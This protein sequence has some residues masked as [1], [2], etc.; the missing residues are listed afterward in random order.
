MI[1]LIA[2]LLGIALIASG[3]FIKVS[4][5][6]FG[7]VIPTATLGIFLIFV[8][9]AGFI[10]GIINT[11]GEVPFFI[12]AFLLGGALFSGIIYAGLWNFLLPHINWGG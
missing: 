11:I 10:R 3:F 1:T 5:T 2:L 12:L 7:L 9:L 6:I 8:I 4:I